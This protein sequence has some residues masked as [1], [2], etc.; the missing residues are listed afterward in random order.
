ME[1]IILTNS[2]TQ[3]AED[4]LQLLLLH[5][6][7]GVKGVRLLLHS[8]MRGLEAGL[9]HLGGDLIGHLH[10]NSVN[11]LEVNIRVFPRFHLLIEKRDG[12]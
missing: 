8:V 5:L 2:S 4:V 3:F 12:Y 9:E 1:T 6:F 10:L 7:L 11:E